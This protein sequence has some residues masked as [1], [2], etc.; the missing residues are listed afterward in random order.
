VNLIQFIPQYNLFVTSSNSKRTKQ[1]VIHIYNFR[2]STLVEDSFLISLKKSK[3]RQPVNQ[4]ESKV[5][6]GEKVKI[7]VSSRRKSQVG[8][9]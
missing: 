9:S 6:K 3:T 7:D 1:A 8:F 2:Q 4:K 5:D